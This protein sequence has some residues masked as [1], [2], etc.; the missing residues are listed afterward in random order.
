MKR[1]YKMDTWR[2]LDE[3]NRVA[4]EAAKEYTG[5][6]FTVSIGEWGVETYLVFADSKEE[7]KAAAIAENGGGDK[8][9]VREVTNA[10]K[11]NK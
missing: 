4:I 8:I 9:K 7:A 10:K 1:V 3:L 5:R 11:Y 6:K 2:G